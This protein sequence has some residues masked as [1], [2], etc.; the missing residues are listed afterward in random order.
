MDT[1]YLN[2]V[3]QT[4]SADE[5]QDQKAETLSGAK[6][7][8]LES[9]G[10]NLEG[11]SG[12][13]LVGGSILGKATG[14]GDTAIESIKTLGD[15]IPGAIQSAEEGI[16]NVRAGVANVQA[17]I[18][19]AQRLAQSTPADETGTELTNMGSTPTGVSETSFGADVE[20]TV[21]AEAGEDIGAELG[22]E[23][24]LDTIGASLTATGI[25][26]PIGGLLILGSV[27]GTAISG[28]EDLFAAHN[29]KP[30]APDLS[31]VPQP[32]LAMGVHN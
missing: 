20:T 30:T 4:A 27:L 8:G 24:V 29:S 21:G 13:L 7:A 25:L 3:M 32:L 31:G 19:N 22:G 2:S 23:A 17:G 15:Q 26:A 14:L 1:N 5:F 18:Q 16:A 11:L 28:I 6:K 10:S 12:G 9:M